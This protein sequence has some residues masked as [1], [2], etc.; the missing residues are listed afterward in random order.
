MTETERLMVKARTA[1]LLSQPFFGTLALRL[2]MIE[3]AA[4]GTASVDGR[5]L[6]YNPD[7]IKGLT[8]AQHQGADARAAR[9]ADRPR[10]DA[11]RGRPSHAQ[12]LPRA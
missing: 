9:R 11:L 4:I 12:R 7:F 1:L 3:D 10:G 8:H 2:K 6:R 5:V